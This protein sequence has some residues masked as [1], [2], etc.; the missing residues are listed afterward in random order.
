MT[1]PK[2]TLTIGDEVKITGGK[3]K[4]LEQGILHTLK[5]T[6]CDVAFKEGEET[7]IKK[8]KIDYIHRVNEGVIEMPDVNDL[9]VCENPEA[10]EE[11]SKK[12]EEKIKEQVMELLENVEDNGTHTDP[13]GAE[14]SDPIE[15]KMEDLHPDEQ[16]FVSQVEDLENRLK[17]VEELNRRC[18]KRNEYLELIL[19]KILS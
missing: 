1:E 11:E 2:K 16:D 8:V 15:M 14:E 19:G 9:V 17:E 3:Y 13:V 5:N 6:Y 4:K 12:A 10:Y 7:I 18:V